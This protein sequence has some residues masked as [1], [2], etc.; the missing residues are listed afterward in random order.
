MRKRGASYGKSHFLRYELNFHKD[1]EASWNR[2][3]E[4][5]RVFAWER[6]IN[7]GNRKTE[8]QAYR[9]YVLSE[10]ST[11]SYLDDGGNSDYLPGSPN[12]CPAD[13]F[14]QEESESP[15]NQK[16]LSPPT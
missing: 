7:Q 11:Q 8:M 3:K 13:G 5:D 1:S 10:G 9:W 15:K 12:T 16:V 14:L 6:I 4:Q 2:S